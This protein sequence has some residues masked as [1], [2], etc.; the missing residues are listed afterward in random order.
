MFSRK[1]KRQA[2]DSANYAAVALAETSLARL[3]LHASTTNRPSPDSLNEIFSK[4]ARHK[5]ILRPRSVWNDS[6]LPL[7]DLTVRPVQWK[8]IPFAIT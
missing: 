4:P 2:N 1:V 8:M 5:A 7:N 6:V 3:G